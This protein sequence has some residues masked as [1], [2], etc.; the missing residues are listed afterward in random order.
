MAHEG[1]PWGQTRQEAALL[2][3]AA[4]GGWAG[5]S[6]GR[7]W[8]QFRER[9]LTLAAVPRLTQ[10]QEGQRQGVSVEQE[11][12]LPPSLCPARLE[13]RCALDFSSSSGQSP[14]LI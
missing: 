10:T 8:Q 2:T 7:A 9:S 12:S 4:S 13:V 11:P 3:P 14:P 5:T 1:A 6:R